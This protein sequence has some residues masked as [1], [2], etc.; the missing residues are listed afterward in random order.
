MNKHKGKIIA[1]VITLLIAVGV[2]FVLKVPKAYAHEHRTVGDY[3][4]VLGWQ[5]EPIYAGVFNGPEL[6]VTNTKTEKPVTGLEETL[7]LTVTF[8]PDSKTLVL[9][10]AYND[11]G[12]Y[13]AFLTPTRPGDY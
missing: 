5:H 1:G 2:F 7:A 6:F 8:G 3:E 4:V 9:E 13:L 12:H 10:P 11:P